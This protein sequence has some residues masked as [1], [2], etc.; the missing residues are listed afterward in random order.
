MSSSSS[1]S[2]L[3]S[4][5]SGSGAGTGFGSASSSSS[6]SSSLLAS[7][8]AYDPYGLYGKQ[9]V[10]TKS[11]QYKKM[12]QEWRNNVFLARSKIQGLGLYA[13]RDIERNTMIIEYIG[14]I[15]RPQL[16]ELREKRY[17]AAVGV[18]SRFFLAHPK[19]SV[20]VN[21]FVK[22]SVSRRIFKTESSCDR[23]NC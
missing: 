17:E 23:W 7:V 1:S 20:P 16:A 2:F 11:S 3:Y 14:E 10:H 8:H 12:K 9:F 15:I 13:A 21:A 22:E 5:A 6:S 19:S 18:I 4:S